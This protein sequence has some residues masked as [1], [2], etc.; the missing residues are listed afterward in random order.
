LE[1]LREKQ[2]ATEEFEILEIVKER[3]V[4]VK[5]KTC[6]EYFCNWKGF[7]VTD[8]WIPE[9]NLRNAQE[10]LQEW[11]YKKAKIHRRK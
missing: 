3:R 5:G 6:K 11:K 10:L 7:G 8:E 9:K 4:K 2:I 1:P